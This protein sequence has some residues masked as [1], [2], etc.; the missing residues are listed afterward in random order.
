MKSS[1]PIKRPLQGNKQRILL[2]VLALFVA[3]GSLALLSL[4]AAGPFV[5]VEPESGSRTA[6]AAGIQDTT[7]SGG[8]AVRFGPASSSTKFTLVVMP[9]TQFT[10]QSWPADFMNM[11]AWIRDKAAELN[12]AYVLHE[13]DVQENPIPPT[14]QYFE[15]ARRAMNQ[16]DGHVPY[17]VAI[18]NHDF[19]AWYTG[20]NEGIATDRRATIFN[21]YFP[22]SK[23]QNWPTFG[24]S[25]PAGTNDNSFHKFRAGGTDWGIVTLKFKPTAAELAW[26]NSIVSAN[27]SRRFIILTHE[28]LFGNGTRTPAGTQMWNELVSKY[29]NVQFV[30]SGHVYPTSAR[31][32]DAGVNGNQVH[33][34]LIDYQAYSVREPNSYIRL[35]TFDT[36]ARTITV[37]SYSPP[38][39]KYM[40]GTAD[41]FVLTGVPFGPVQ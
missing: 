20:Q 10:A 24:S 7:A 19:D 25:H 12:I 13:G 9:D 38:F 31:R 39:N 22:V 1:T 17:V 34:L 4:R 37:K 36:A 27:P 5:A 21:R 15:N 6:P 28:Y 33:Q 41:D 3:A 30:F 23:F 32:V 29:K 8:Q 26:A 18:G 14:Y 35:M 2:L 11:T 40:T 16:L